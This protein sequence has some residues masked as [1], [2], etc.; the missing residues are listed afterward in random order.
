[1]MFLLVVAAGDL[2]HR[3]GL[4]IQLHPLGDMDL[5]APSRPSLPDLRTY[6]LVLVGNK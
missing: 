5:H 6:L 2:E 1:M 3:G 4:C